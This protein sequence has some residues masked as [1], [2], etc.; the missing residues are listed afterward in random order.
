MRSYSY[1]FCIAVLVLLTAAVFIIHVGTG[2]TYF[3]YDQLIRILLG[4][5]TPKSG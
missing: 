5:G 1:G 4:G 3:S 2:F